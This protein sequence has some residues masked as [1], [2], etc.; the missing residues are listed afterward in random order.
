MIQSYLVDE[1]EN[2]TLNSDDEAFKLLAKLLESSASL[3]NVNHGDLSVFWTVEILEVINCSKHF[4]TVAISCLKALA[5]L[6]RV[7]SRERSK[8]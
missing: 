8:F 7:R 6:S 1:E 4:V 2:D 3:A 5:W